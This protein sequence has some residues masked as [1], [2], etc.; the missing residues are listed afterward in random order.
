VVVPVAGRRSL[1][2]L[3][4]SFHHLCAQVLVRESGRS[5]SSARLTPVFR[6]FTS[7]EPNTCGSD[8]TLRPFGRA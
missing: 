1:V 6:G 5:M 4:D 3:S 7:G 8:T 2:W